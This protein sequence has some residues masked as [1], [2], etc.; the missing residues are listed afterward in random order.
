MVD[1]L[2]ELLNTNPLISII[3]GFVLAGLAMIIFRNE[4]KKII[5]KK[6][7]LYTEDEVKSFGNY[8]FEKTEIK[9]FSL[10]VETS[11]KE[12]LTIE[13]NLENWKIFSRF[14]KK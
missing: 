3:L 10:G 12:T 9:N 14:L 7:N 2:F 1:K 5:I 11:E 4:I 6:Y 8:I 13:E